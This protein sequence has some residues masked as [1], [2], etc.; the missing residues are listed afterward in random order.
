MESVYRRVL[1]ATTMGVDCDIVG[2]D[3]RVVAKLATR[4]LGEVRRG[5]FLLPQ[6]LA[7]YERVLG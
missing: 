7:K 3:L 4:L 5:E 1:D 6:D 2:G